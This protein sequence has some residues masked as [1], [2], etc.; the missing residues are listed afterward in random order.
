MT[1]VDTSVLLAQLLA[2][3][4]A[5]P[6]AFWDASLISSRLIE[7]EVLTRVNARKLGATHGE[8]ARALLGRLAMVELST[9]VLAR[10]LDP[11]PVPVRTLDALHLATMVFLRERDPSLVVAT[12]DDRLTLAAKKLKFVVREP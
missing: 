5:P 10:A 11:F 3:D 2:E 7:Y 8:A 12:Y 4:R 9:H 6:A 1:Y